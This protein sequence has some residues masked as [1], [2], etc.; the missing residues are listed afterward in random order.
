MTVL[1]LFHIESWPLPVKYTGIYI[2]I[3]KVYNLLYNKT[4]RTFKNSY[5]HIISC[6]RKTQEFDSNSSLK[7]TFSSLVC[8][9][10]IR[11]PDLW[12]QQVHGADASLVCFSMLSTDCSTLTNGVTPI[13]PATN[14]T[15]LLFSMSRDGVECGPSINT[16]VSQD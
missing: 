16:W 8:F 3:F 10:Q 2:Y 4:L 7:L 12:S 15:C 14:I 11:L 1:T 6:L 9:L 5:I 13:P